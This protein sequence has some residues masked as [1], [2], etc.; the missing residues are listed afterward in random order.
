MVQE[1]GDTNLQDEKGR[2]RPSNFDGQAVLAAVEEDESL[3]TS[4]LVGSLHGSIVS[5]SSERYGN[6]LDRS[7]TNSPTTTKP[8]VSEF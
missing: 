6:W 2:G 1:S 8:N 5:K 4:M 3:T 7:P